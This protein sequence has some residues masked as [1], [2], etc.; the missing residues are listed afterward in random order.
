MGVAETLPEFSEWT[1]HTSKLKILAS[2]AFEHYK[3]HRLA[4]NGTFPKFEVLY[5]SLNMVNSTEIS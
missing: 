1:L 4:H 5:C 3:C 2:Q